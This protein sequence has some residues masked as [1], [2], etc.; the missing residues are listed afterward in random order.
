MLREHFVSVPVSYAN[1]IVFAVQNKLIVDCVFTSTQPE[2][3][4]QICSKLR[5][6]YDNLHVHNINGERVWSAHS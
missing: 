4:I 3:A 1:S 5:S 6:N 2:E